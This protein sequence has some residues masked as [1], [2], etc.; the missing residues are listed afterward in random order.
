VC[1]LIVVVIQDS[2][3]IFKLN[4][5]RDTLS[6]TSFIGVI[7]ICQISDSVDGFSRRY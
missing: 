6:C 7:S 4:F 2:L 1:K 5:A 3:D